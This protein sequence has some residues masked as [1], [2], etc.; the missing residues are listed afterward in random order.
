MLPMRPELIR[1]EQKPFVPDDAGS[2]TAAQ[3]TG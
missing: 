3:D 1:H 2:A